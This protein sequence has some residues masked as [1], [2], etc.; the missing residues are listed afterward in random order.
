MT[1]KHT[2]IVS[3][4]IVGWLARLSDAVT[5]IYNYYSHKL[6][7]CKLLRFKYEFDV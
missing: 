3:A 1:N 2:S 4:A 6:K 5:E 7:V